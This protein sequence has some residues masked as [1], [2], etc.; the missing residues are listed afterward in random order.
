MKPELE[1]ILE[2]I[3][4]QHESLS[5]DDEGDRK[6]L[7]K[8]LAKGLTPKDYY[9]VQAIAKALFPTGEVDE[10]FYDCEIAIYTGLYNIA[11]AGSEEAFLVED[12][13]KTL[14]D[15]FE[16]EDDKTIVGVVSDIDGP[17]MW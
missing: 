16:D 17:D 1:E 7:I 3:I 10:S 12:N 6:T 4:N 2:N 5:L 9:Q 13:N 14:F 11:A 8:A 15:S